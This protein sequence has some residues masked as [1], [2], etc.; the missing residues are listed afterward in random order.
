[1]PEIPKHNPENKN[2]I[3]LNEI[4]KILAWWKEADKTYNKDWVTN[5]DIREKYLEFKKDFDKINKDFDKIKNNTKSNLSEFK[6]EIQNFKEKSIRYET[7]KT[8]ASIIYYIEKDKEKL[9]FNKIIKNL[10]LWYKNISEVYKDKEKLKI[11]ITELKWKKWKNEKQLLAYLEP[12]LNFHNFAKKQTEQKDKNWNIIKEGI[13]I[14]LNE[15]DKKEIEKQEKV[16]YEQVKL[17][18]KIYQNSQLKKTLEKIKQN[19]TIDKLYNNPKFLD[20]LNKKSPKLQRPIVGICRLSLWDW[21]KWENINTY[22]KQITEILKNPKD[23]NKLLSDLN[24]FIKKAFLEQKKENEKIKLDKETKEILKK[25]NPEYIKNKNFINFEAIENDFDI[26]LAKKSEE[27]KKSWNKINSNNIIKYIEEFINIKW[28]KNINKTWLDNIKNDLK[29]KNKTQVFNNFVKKISENPEKYFKLIKNWKKED[30]EKLWEENKNETLEKNI[31]KWKKQYKIKQELNSINNKP[32]IDN[33]Y[34]IDFKQLPSEITDNNTITLADWTKID[35][36]SSEEYKILNIN[37]NTWT[38]WNP[39]AL[40]N[41]VNAKEKLD[42][43]WLD[44]VWKNR[45]SIFKVMINNSDFA[46]NWINIED[47]NLIDKREFNNLLQFILKIYW[48]ENPSSIESVNYAKILKINEIWAISDKRNWFT[49]LS[50]IWQKFVEIWFFNSSWNVDIFW[51]NKLRQYVK[52]WYKL[53]NS[54]KEN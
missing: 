8:M 33:S 54:N 28:L 42:K 32:I 31:Q 18:E 10:G 20:Y 41:L 29:L 53:N 2:Q 6:K 40:K 47:N 37:K 13:E 1:M 15:K 7:I 17:Y 4:K 12:I 50:N 3:S 39:E 11:V 26:F 52:N 48:D 44:F 43:L 36:I 5:K 22:I 21:W 49:W 16:F 9:G 38:I 25:S 46:L 24:S 30:I 23:F 27:L 34:N 51:E 14:D 45:N 35:N 19:K